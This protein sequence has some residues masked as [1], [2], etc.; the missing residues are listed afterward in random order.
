MKVD[1]LLTVNDREKA[2]VGVE[3]GGNPRLIISCIRKGESTFMPPGNTRLL[4][5]TLCNTIANRDKDVNFISKF[6]SK[7]IR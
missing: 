4:L 1:D 2:V 5:H 6:V 7:E 3:G